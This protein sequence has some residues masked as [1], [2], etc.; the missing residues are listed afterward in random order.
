MSVTAASREDV[1][2]H[3]ELPLKR[4]YFAVTESMNEKNVKHTRENVNV[5]LVVV[6]RSQSRSQSEARRATCLQVFSGPLLLVSLL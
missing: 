6:S 3:T 1:H 2:I 5:K 4:V